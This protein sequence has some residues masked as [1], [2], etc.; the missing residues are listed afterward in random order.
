MYAHAKER[1]YQYSQQVLPWLKRHTEA[2]SIA[3]QI[4]CLAGALLAAYLV[5]FIDTLDER[6]IRNDLSPALWYLPLK[7]SLLWKFGQFKV[8][9]AYF[10][11][12]DL[13]RIFYATSLACLIALIAF[14]VGSLELSFPRRL[15][16][17]DAALSTLFLG[18][19]RLALRSLFERFDGSRSPKEMRRRVAI[20]GAGDLGD[21]LMAEALSTASNGYEVVALLD[22][23]P[24]KQG[25]QLHGLRIEPIPED[26]VRLVAG[27]GVQEIVVAIN[28]PPPERLQT[29]NQA[30]KEE[31]LVLRIVP[32]ISLL[33]PQTAHLRHARKVR[34]EDLLGR[35]PVSL[36]NEVIGKLIEGANVMV[37]GAGGSIGSELSRQIMGLNPRKLTLLDQSEYL[38]YEIEQELLELGYGQ[39]LEPVV[40]DVS[41]RL[42]I[43][44]LLE[45]T[46]PQILFHAAAYKHV[47]I[48]EREPY[49]ALRN[50]TL[51]TLDLAETVSALG[52]E[53]FILISTDK[54]IR[55]SSVMGASKRL[56]ERA[57]LEVQQRPENRTRFSAVRFGNVMGSSGSVLPRFQRQIAAGGPVTVTHP[58][59]QRYFMTIPEAVGLV[60]QCAVLGEGGDLFVLDMGKALFIDDVAR[61]MIE[62][63]GFRPDIDIPIHYTGLRPG[64]KLFEEIIREG[65]AFAPTR[66]P[67]VKRYLLNEDDSELPQAWAELR[68]LDAAAPAEVHRAWLRRCLPDYNTN[69]EAKA[70]K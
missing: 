6:S 1:L 24:A 11:I 28:R 60:L 23:D 9:L 18:G 58:K 44:R 64:E 5:S 40:A 65:E 57:L 43:R 50:N 63:S 36:E 39:R 32:E 38:L 16:L 62:L 8:F 3:G 10:R 48:M 55:P 20:I 47:P 35:E 67:R 4:F 26:F 30:A 19:F 37:T 7:A 53:R 25:R 45:E 70:A 52:L 27:K 31:G 33:A 21:R 22:D 51:A 13:L 46:Q 49:E 61:R 2:V 69:P 34:I 12:P 56:A 29:W 54:A 42:R 17:A 66:H 68:D 41:D 59:M 15:I 14:E